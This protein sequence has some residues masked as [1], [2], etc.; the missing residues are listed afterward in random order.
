MEKFEVL[1]LVTLI[2]GKN[3]TFKGYNPFFILINKVISK[4]VVKYE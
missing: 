1:H 2:G 4:R 3:I